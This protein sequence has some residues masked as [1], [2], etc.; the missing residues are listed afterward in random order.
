M[1]LQSLLRNA[2]P[3]HVVIR[4]SGNAARLEETIKSLE[5]TVRICEQFLGSASADQVTLSGQIHMIRDA[6]LQ[7]ISQLGEGALSGAVLLFSPGPPE[8]AL[9]GVL[10]QS[11][12]GDFTRAATE[13]PYCGGFD[14]AALDPV[15]ASDSSGFFENEPLTAA[16]AACAFRPPLVLGDEEIGLAVRRSRTIAM[17]MPTAPAD[18]HLTKLGVNFHRGAERPIAVSLD[19]R[20][21]HVFLIGMTG[22]GK[23]TLMLSMLLQ[24]L[25]EGHG[26]CLLDPHGDLADDL[27]AR[28]P[29]C[30]EKHLLLIDL[31]DR[32]YP[33]P[34]N[35]LH[36]QTLDERDL[37][38]DEFLSAL[39]RVYREPQM[40]GP[41]FEMN[42]RGMMKLLMGDRRFDDFTPTLLEFPKVYLIKEFREFLL[43]RSQ[44]DQVRDFIAEIQRVRGE[45]ELA[46]LAPYITNKL[47]RFLQ[48]RHLRRIVGH[49]AMALNFTDSRRPASTGLAWSWQLNMR[50]S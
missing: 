23:S 10:G 32:Q 28:F 22:T 47:A 12:S 1:L 38:I 6:A 37:I 39:L 20:L 40:F 13:N 17:T 7:R 35:L 21:K 34:L 29:K 42:F 46:N 5:S 26:L 16:E 18:E 19:H 27:L 8:E 15:T 49:G 4:V 24:D 33:V 50:R 31:A 48:D 2:T 3:Q 9:A 43:N 41:I 25:R 45:N 30:R 44:D 36:W 11:I 14:V